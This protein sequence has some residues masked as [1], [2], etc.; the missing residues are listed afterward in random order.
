MLKNTKQI[1]TSLKKENQR[2]IEENSKFKEKAKE[3][4][5]KDRESAKDSKEESIMNSIKKARKLIDSQ[6]SHTGR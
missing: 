3:N 5:R 2:L 4:E 6:N 1:I